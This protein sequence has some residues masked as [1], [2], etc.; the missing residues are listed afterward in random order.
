MCH[1]FN[2]VNR[3]HPTQKRYTEEKRSKQNQQQQQ[4]KE[5]TWRNFPG[6]NSVIKQSKSRVICEQCLLTEPQWEEVK[7]ASSNSNVSECLFLANHRKA[8]RSWW[9]PW[10]RR[11]TRWNGATKRRKKRR[12]M[13]AKT[14]WVFYAL[15]LVKVHLI[16]QFGNWRFRYLFVDWHLTWSVTLKLSKLH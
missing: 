12:R 7:L 2:N 11:S 5:C 16:W 10:R 4:K 15:Q 6:L 14:W 1:F 8:P 3:I 9:R 13:L